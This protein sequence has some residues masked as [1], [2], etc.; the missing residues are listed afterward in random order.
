MKIIRTCEECP[1][2]S[3]DSGGAGYCAAADRSY[4]YA[5]GKKDIQ[6]FCPLDDASPSIV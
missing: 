3:Y 1:H 2:G 6:P 5:D 4:P